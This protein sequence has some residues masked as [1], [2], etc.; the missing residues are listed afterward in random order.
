MAEAFAAWT[1][2]TGV[3]AVLSKEEAKA[4]IKVVWSHAAGTSLAATSATEIASGPG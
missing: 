4:S 3:T 2:A 1:A